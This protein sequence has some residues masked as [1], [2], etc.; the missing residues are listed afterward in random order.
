MQCSAHNAQ[1][2]IFEGGDLQITETALRV[3]L[4][5]D[6]EQ[7]ASGRFRVSRR[8]A[9]LAGAESLIRIGNDEVKFKLDRESP[10]CGTFSLILVTAQP[11]PSELY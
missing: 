3:K 9:G 10:G 6:L 4:T 11:G 2:R 8:L 1:A 5:R 7:G